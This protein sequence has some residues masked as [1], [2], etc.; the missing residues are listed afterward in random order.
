MPTIKI[1]NLTKV[2]SNVERYF[3]ALRSHRQN[4]YFTLTFTT[5]AVISFSRILLI[6][7]IQVNWD[8]PIIIDGAYRL[9]LGQTIHNDF[10]SPTGLLNLFPGA[11]GME[12][13]GPNLLGLNFG[14]SLFSLILTLVLTSI[15]LIV[16]SRM[17]AFFLSIG[18]SLFLASPSTLSSKDYFSYTSTYNMTAYAVLSFI[19]VTL[20]GF[21]YL[22]T[23]KKSSEAFRINTAI[24]FAIALLVFIKFPIAL[25]SLLPLTIHLFF[26]PGSKMR[27]LWSVI[28]SFSITIVFFLFS[29]R[30]SPE[31]ILRDFGI[32]IDSRNDLISQSTIQISRY[33]TQSNKYLLAAIFILYLFS[34]LKRGDRL[35]N[36][37]LVTTAI[38]ID[39]AVQV[40]IQ[41]PAEIVLPL[42]LSLP[43]ISQYFK[44]PGRYNALSKVFGITLI[45][46]FLLFTYN[47][48]FYYV[49]TA[50]QQIFLEKPFQGLRDVRIESIYENERK[51]DSAVSKFVNKNT[52]LIVVGCNDSYSVKYS[53]QHAIDTPLYWHDG[54]TFSES[55]LRANNFFNPNSIFQEVNLVGISYS[56]P[57]GD[58]AKL[59]EQYYLKYL[60]VEF[61]VIG[62]TPD[63]TIWEKTK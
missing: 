28:L 29:F 14:L 11:V 45:F 52:K 41:Q 40:T 25:I 57:H 3:Q 13:F 37:T 47:N 39:L 9:Y 55:A 46:P 18:I 4:L 43:L 56:C 31:K 21:Y 22:P 50:S 16:L 17:Q 8:A 49:S 62:T 6:P 63:Y 44:N 60:E 34:V 10:S 54:V 15:S 53:L 38:V 59:F 24:G 20:L 36:L 33:F 51:F 42:I 19:C 23:S 7:M 30:I 35:R 58:S 12:I 2:R 27:V 26:H 5:V 48:G 32:V 1:I 61:K